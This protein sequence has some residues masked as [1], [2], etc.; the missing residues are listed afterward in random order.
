MRASAAAVGKAWYLHV[1]TYAYARYGYQEVATWYIPGRQVASESLVGSRNTK[2][3]SDSI[4]KPGVF[5]VCWLW[6]YTGNRSGWMGGRTLLN[7]GPGK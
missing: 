3:D 6:I 5:W 2:C 7:D 1:P 4:A